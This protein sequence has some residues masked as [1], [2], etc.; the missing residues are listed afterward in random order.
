VNSI[1]GNSG[2][3][4]GNITFDF[5]DAKLG[6]TCSMLHRSATIPTIPVNGVIISG[7]YEVNVDNYMWFHLRRKTPGSEVVEITIGQ[8]VI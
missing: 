8:R 5:T 7:M 1:H 3:I 4:T 6:K 2:F